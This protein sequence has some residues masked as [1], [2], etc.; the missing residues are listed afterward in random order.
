MDTFTS[1]EGTIHDGPGGSSAPMGPSSVQEQILAAPGA[2]TLVPVR[3]AMLDTLG[4]S[5]AVEDLQ[6]ANLIAWTSIAP[7]Y[8]GLARGAR[9]MATQVAQSP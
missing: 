3:P 5:E 7:L 8:S 1:G 9:T 6:G 4:A 2:G